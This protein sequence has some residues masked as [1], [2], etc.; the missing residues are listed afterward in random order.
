MSVHITCIDKQYSKQ[1]LDIFVL[2]GHHDVRDLQYNTVKQCF[3]QL[4]SLCFDAAS[5][6]H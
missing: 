4:T 5:K 1:K 2:F 6:R 3:R